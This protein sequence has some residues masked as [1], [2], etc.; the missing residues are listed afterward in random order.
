MKF[1]ILYTLIILFIY[2]GGYAQ[3]LTGR[4]FDAS[5]NS[6]LSGAS[7]SYAGK[8]TTTDNSGRFSINCNKAAVITV[9]YVGYETSRIVVKNCNDELSIGLTPLHGNL[10]N[11]E[12]TATSAENKSLLYQPQSITKLSEVELKR[13][14]GLYFEE[15]INLNV[16]GVAF[17]KRAVNSGQSFNIRGYGNGARA[18]NV[19][20]NFDGQGYKVYLNGIPVTDAEGITVMDDIDFGSISNVEVVKGPAGTLYG[21][22]I[23]GAVN[24]RTVRPEKGKTSIGQEVMIGNY[25]L[26]RYTTTLQTAGEKSSL[27]LNYGR[28]KSAGFMMHNASHKDFINLVSEFQP[29]EKQSIIAYV[30]YS[31]SYDQRPGEQT[32]TQYLAK[33]D[34]GNIEYFKRN[35]HSHVISYRAGVGQTYAFNNWLSNTTSLFGT[36]LFTD[37]SSGGGWTDK[38]S[39]NYG[40]RSVFDTKFSL[41][42]KLSLTGLTGFELQ[43]QNAQTGGYNMKPDP[44]AANQDIKKWQYGE[45]Y[46]VLDTTTSNTVTGSSTSSIFTEWTLSMPNDLSFTAGVGV[47]NMRL[48]LEDRYK[49]VTAT[50]AATFERSYKKMVSPHFAVNKVFNKMLSVYASYSRGYKAPVSSYFFTP[51]PAVTGG[52][53][54][55]AQIDSLLK[56]EIG[57]QYEIGTKGSLLHDKLY[58]EVAIFNALFKNKMTAIAVKNPNDASGGTLY[59]IM[60]NA[61]RQNHKGL[62]VLLKYTVF[63]SENSFTRSI[64]PFANLTYSDFKYENFFL[65]STVKRAAPNQTKDSAITTNYDGYKVAGVPKITANG[66]LDIQAAY[67]LYGNVTYAYRDDMTVTSNGL[68]NGVPFHTPSYSL[69]NAKIGLQQT[70]SSHFDLDVYFG[71]NNITSIQ[72]PIKIFV[73]QLPDAFVPGPAKANYFGGVKVKY[74]F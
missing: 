31:N 55:T 12:I 58:Y 18:R 49:P 69:L 56:P 45:P 17:E 11:I 68:V 59:T 41:S 71:V 43:R 16:P 7:V 24:L 53:A 39:L 40:S 27:L 32:V 19:S 29:K 66:G 35:A 22:A 73:N 64:R 21:L 51:I 38:V 37:A 10:N 6:S 60:A 62:E 28:Q 65:Q 44:H 25:G 48:G 72:Y 42:D 23:A 70:L 26:Q 67:G 9:S 36:G 63:Q 33:S 61:G 1:K 52:G 3:K 8:G 5:N 47:S 50:K 74:I 13:G 2:S 14:T 4:V 34:T 20:S 30:G 54:A 46:L 15:V 57:D